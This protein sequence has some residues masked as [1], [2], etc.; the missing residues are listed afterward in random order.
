MIIM[1]LAISTSI[2]VPKRSYLK[3]IGY[4]S[5]LQGDFKIYIYS[6]NNILGGG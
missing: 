3:K 5:K 4:H 1:H 2:V 6:I